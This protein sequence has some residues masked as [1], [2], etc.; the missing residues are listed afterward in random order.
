MKEGVQSGWK[1]GLRYRTVKSKRARVEVWGE[2]S[3]SQEEMLAERRV[4]L[5]CPQ[6]GKLLS[7]TLPTALLRIGL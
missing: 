6:H 1:S 2:D 7:S 5:Q 3:R 4:L